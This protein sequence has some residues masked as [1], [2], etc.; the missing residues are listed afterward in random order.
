MNPA[1]GNSASQSGTDRFRW[2]V[3]VSQ[4]QAIQSQDDGLDQGQWHLGS[5]VVAV[6]PGV[7]QM[8][9]KKITKLQHSYKF[10]E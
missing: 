8:P 6:A 5:T 1:R 3:R 9:S 4:S 10:V 2:S 7:D